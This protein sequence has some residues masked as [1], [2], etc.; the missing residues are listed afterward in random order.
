[1]RIQS[2][3]MMVLSL[4]WSLLLPTPV[5]R[6][7]EPARPAEVKVAAVQVLGYDKT[8]LPRAGFDPSEVVARFIARAAGD[9]A[10]LVV[11][12]EYLLGRIAVPGAET[13]RIA[14]A[15]AAG[16]IHVIVGCWEVFEDGS[17]ANTALLFDRS[18]K[19]A[20]KYRKVHAAVDHHEGQPPWSKPP[21]GKDLDW[22]LRNDP[23]W[24]MKRGDDFPVFDLDFGRIGILTC[25]DGWFPES[26]R[27]LSLR[28]AEV[29]VW[30]NGRKG[31]VE[32]FLVR[33]AM[34][35]D[36]VAM[37]ATNQAYGSGTMIGQ[38]PAQILAACTEPKESY[39]TATIDLQR[40][41]KAR[42]N[43]RNR[44]QRRPDVYAEI[45]RPNATGR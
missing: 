35:Q 32:D 36:E 16:K 42:Q 3:S 9:G 41:R 10:Q 31:P 5:V 45:V 25:Y 13:G 2:N 40:I 14:R 1:M 7:D 24:M 26:A 44:P 21:Q 28:G 8:D 37:I 22:F 43:S 39:I 27:I 12:P 11:F 30:I 34:F 18:G 17:F 29:L 6:A 4:Y 33:S 20:G 19:I 38:W 23:E 15:A